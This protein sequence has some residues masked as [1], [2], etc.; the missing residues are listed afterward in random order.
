MS[1]FGMINSCPIARRFGLTR[2]LA[3]IIACISTPNCAAIFDKV[4]P[5]LTTY[6]SFVPVLPGTP[7]VP[8]MIVTVVGVG[9]KM[10]GTTVAVGFVRIVASPSGVQ[11]GI[12][13]T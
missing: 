10:P 7:G 6:I 4:S 5:D 2:L 9:R 11:L 1:Y 8:P 3:S 12:V 13:M